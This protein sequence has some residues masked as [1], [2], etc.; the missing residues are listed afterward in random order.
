[1]KRDTIDLYQIHWHDGKREISDVMEDL[2]KY[3]KQG[4]IRWYGISN[5][6]LSLIDTKLRPEGLVSFS[7]E[8]SLIQRKHE[9]EIIN[10]TMQAIHTLHG[11]KNLTF[12]A[13]G[14]LAQ[15]LLSGKY[16]RHSV[17]ADNDIRSREHSVFSEKHWDY[18]EP[19]LCKLHQI[20]LENN[21]NMS[22][23]ALRF[24]LDSIPSSMVL[25]GI[26][27]TI[28]LNENQG[29]LG[30]NLAEKDIK[31]LKKISDKILTLRRQTKIRSY[32]SLF[33]KWAE[34]IRSGSG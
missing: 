6:P 16:N 5:I 18:N 27:N 34:R 13:W 1:M 32:F 3:R 7:M 22:Q 20:S 8:Y 2:E 12:I 33:L 9:P 11:G 15:G 30:W 21:K 31:A 29:T 26:K 23:V 19:I 14:A 17:F 24:V 10:E 28:Q 4:K 25:T